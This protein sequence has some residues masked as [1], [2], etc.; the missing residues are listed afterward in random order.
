MSIDLDGMLRVAIGQDS[1][2]PFPV[3]EEDRQALFV[4]GESHGLSNGFIRYMA[5]TLAASYAHG[6][7]GRWQRL[8]DLWSDSR[9]DFRPWTSLARE[10]A[11]LRE[12][13]ADLRRRVAEVE[14][15]VPEQKMVI[16]SAMSLD[17]ARDA[18]KHLFRTGRVLYYSD[19]AV[20]LGL[21]LETVVS[22]CD[23]LLS[24]GEVVWS[25]G[26]LH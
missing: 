11:V 19:I 8:E 15:R 18:I 20:E 25:D 13:L 16:L 5:T 22:V 12:D 6:T 23:E 3:E 10:N 21:P 17:E 9:S 26:G 4:L 2:S 7:A 1:D 14:S 24:A